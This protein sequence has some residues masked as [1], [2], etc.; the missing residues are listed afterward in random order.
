M[1]HVCN[2][3]EK[4]TCGDYIKFG[5]LS[6]VEKSYRLSTYSENSAICACSKLGDTIFKSATKAILFKPQKRLVTVITS[7]IASIR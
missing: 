6:N 4:Q 3:C 5:A 2:A 1:V 7:I